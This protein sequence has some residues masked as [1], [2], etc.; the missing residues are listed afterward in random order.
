MFIKFSGGE[1][2]RNGY[3]KL[4]HHRSVIK[5]YFSPRAQFF[6]VF[7][8]AFPGTFAHRPRFLSYLIA[9]FLLLTFRK[10]FSECNYAVHP[11]TLLSDN[12][13]PPKQRKFFRIIKFYGVLHSGG[14]RNKK[15]ARVR[16]ESKLKD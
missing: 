10:N 9:T 1:I 6:T 11:L 2:R 14:R 5:F 3:M 8:P 15:R 16:I 4:H 13:F 12:I 7:L